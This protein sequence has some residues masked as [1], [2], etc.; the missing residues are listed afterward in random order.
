[1]KE[2]RRVANEARIV[3]ESATYNPKEDPNAEGTD[4]F[5]TLF[6]GRLAYSATEKDVRR[7]LE[8]YGAIKNVVLVKDKQGRPRGYAFVEFERESDLKCAVSLL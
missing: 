3:E 1:M 5:K 4:P 6:V 8:R 2:L 7:A